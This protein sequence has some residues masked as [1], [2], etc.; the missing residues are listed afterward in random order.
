M[1]DPSKAKSRPRLPISKSLQIEVFKRDG[2]MWKSC[3]S[4]GDRYRT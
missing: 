3:G 2:W 1:S 4:P